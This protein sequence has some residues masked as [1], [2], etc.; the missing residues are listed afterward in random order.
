MLK[1]QRTQICI[2]PQQPLDKIV[3]DLEKIVEN[4]VNPYNSMF[5]AVEKFSVFFFFLPWEVE[6]TKIWNDFNV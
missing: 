6:M 3:Y 2:Y 1:F 4:Q 5:S